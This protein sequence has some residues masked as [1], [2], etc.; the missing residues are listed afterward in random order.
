MSRTTLAEPHVDAD[1]RLIIPCGCGCS[2]VTIAEWV[3]WDGEEPNEWFLE[4]WQSDHGASW[5]WRWKQIWRALLGREA[6][7][8]DVCWRPEQITLLR[9][10]LNERAPK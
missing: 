4:F 6:I 7:S 9:D 3:D 2:Y 10:W 1:R 8:H 5:R